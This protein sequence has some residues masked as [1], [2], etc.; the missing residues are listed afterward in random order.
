MVLTS[1][2]DTDLRVWI[3]ERIMLHELT[4]EVSSLWLWLKSFVQD[5]TDP[6]TGFPHIVADNSPARWVASTDIDRILSPV[7]WD[8]GSS[9]KGAINDILESYLKDHHVSIEE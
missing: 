9:T 1:T 7:I 3:V 2:F 8:D 6:I 5:G 4:R